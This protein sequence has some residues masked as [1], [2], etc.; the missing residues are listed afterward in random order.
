M[1]VYDFTAKR[2]DGSTQSLSE[3]QGNVLLIVNTA[4]KCGFT[5]QYEGLEALYRKYQDEGFVILGFPCNQFGRQ[6][7][8]SEAEIAQ[9]CQMTYDVTFP[10]FAK[11]DVNG[12]NAHPLYQYLKSEAGG[13]LGSQAIKWNFTKFLVNRQGKVLKRFAPTVSPSEM[14]QDV[15][16]ALRG[17]A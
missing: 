9:F 17:E 3:Y 2:I 12:R 8:G 10:M 5:P 13:V 7:P 1:S 15:V 16:E 11:I 6:E 14:E 4:S